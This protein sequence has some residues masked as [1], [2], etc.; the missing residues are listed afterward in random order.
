MTTIIAGMFD[1]IDKAEGAVG[2]LLYAGFQARDVSSFSS[3]QH[4]QHATP[5]NGDDEED[6]DPGA[7]DVERDTDKGATADEVA[8]DEVADELGAGAAV[9]AVVAG[10]RSAGVV[11]A[12]RIEDRSAEQPAISILNTQGAVWSMTSSVQ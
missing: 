8:A 3:N 4:G 6:D 10:P 2:K 5:I 11:V 7:S 9:R 1:T 12:V